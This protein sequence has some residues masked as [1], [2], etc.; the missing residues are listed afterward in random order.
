MPWNYLA[1]VFLTVLHLA[2]LGVVL[3]RARETARPH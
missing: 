3:W 1:G 2:F